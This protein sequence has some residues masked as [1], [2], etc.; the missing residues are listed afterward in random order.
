MSGGK[1]TYEKKNK[2]TQEEKGKRNLK[3]TERGILSVT[4]NHVPKSKKKKK[5]E[6]H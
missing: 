5:M 1:K 3:S 4:R 6:G 2:K